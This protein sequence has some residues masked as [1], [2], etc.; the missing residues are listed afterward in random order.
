MFIAHGQHTK[1][2]IP[3]AF[4]DKKIIYCEPIGYNDRITDIILEQVAEE[5]D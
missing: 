1:E 3:K 4:N 5:K 2:D